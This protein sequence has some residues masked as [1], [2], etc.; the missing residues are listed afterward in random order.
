MWTDANQI[1]ELLRKKFPDQK[2]R[3]VFTQWEH[4]DPDED[5]TVTTFNGYLVET[6][7][8]ENQFEGL[9][10]AFH[11]KTEDEEE[12]IE[13]LMDFPMDGED[14]VAEQSEQ[15]LRIFGNESLLELT[16]I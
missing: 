5:E 14:I 1:P 12:V 16:K 2:I 4:D 7:V 3:A 6:S 8:A 13:I 9:D 10:G 15:T 11:F